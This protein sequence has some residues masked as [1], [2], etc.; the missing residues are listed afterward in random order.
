[1]LGDLLSE[2]R[3]T[4]ILDIAYT[5]SAQAFVALI[6]LVLVVT[7]AFTG[8][9]DVAVVA[10]QLIERFGL[11]GAARDAMQVL[12]RTPGVGSGVYWL[13]LVITLYSAFSL[14]RRVTRAYATV[15]DVPPLPAGQQWKGLVWLGVQV[16]MIIFAALG[17]LLGYILGTRARRR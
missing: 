8:K 14:S 4:R 10:R 1:M 7:A 3:R 9:G 12:F 13:G 11:V 5:L 15:W 6:P 16:V 2:A 17:L